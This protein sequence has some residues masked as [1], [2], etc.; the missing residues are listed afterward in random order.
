[1]SFNTA[2]NCQINLDLLEEVSSKPVTNRSPFSEKKFISAIN[3]CNNL[4]TPELNK[5]YFKRYI[6]DVTFLKNLIAITNACIELGHW[7]SH[8]KVSTSIIIPK[9][10]K[11]SYNS[12]KAFQSIVLLN[13]I[14]KLIKKVI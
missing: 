7:L 9:P 6:K 14:S 11:E 4:L 12:L 8:F 1:M 5:R 2:Q 3:K 13:I 10:N